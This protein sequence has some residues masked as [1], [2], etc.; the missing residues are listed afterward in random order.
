MAPL[1]A[2]RG[3][4]QRARVQ[5]VGALGEDPHAVDPEEQRGLALTRHGWGA[6][7]AADEFDGA[8]ADPTAE[9][10]AFLALPIRSGGAGKPRRDVEE[11]GLAHAVRPPALPPADLRAE[12]RRHLRLDRRVAAL[13]ADSQSGRG[14]PGPVARQ[15]ELE[16][17][18]DGPRQ[19]QQHAHVDA[20]P[21]VRRRRAVH[22]KNLRHDGR[23]E[24]RGGSAEEDAVEYARVGE[25]RVVVAELEVVRLLPHKG[26]HAL[27]PLA[28][29]CASGQRDGN[30]GNGRGGARESIVVLPAG[31]C[32]T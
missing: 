13:R 12:H 17:L 11:L 5:V 31:S 16:A 6:M 20:K 7:H 2:L 22:S 29:P 30:D 19:R 4:G 27:P 24:G 32:R 9:R 26:A 3:E 21:A 14:S 10:R 8:K 25:G 28:P 1:L 23:E 15:L 18:L